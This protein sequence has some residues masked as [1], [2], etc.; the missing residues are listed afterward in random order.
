MF[1]V[2]QRGL[3]TDE[4]KMSPV[5]VVISLLSTYAGLSTAVAGFVLDN[6][7]MVVAGLLLVASASVMIRWPWSTRRRIG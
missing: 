2:E 4:P 7:A 5:P 1:N 3:T 6:T